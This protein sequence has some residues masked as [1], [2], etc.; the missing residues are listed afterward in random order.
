[1]QQHIK[2]R[3][4]LELFEAK[5]IIFRD[6][7]GHYTVDAL[8]GLCQKELLSDEDPIVS[9]W[10]DVKQALPKT[11]SPKEIHWVLACNSIGEVFTATLIQHEN[12]A[13]WHQF[14]S[15]YCDDSDVCFWDVCFWM[16]LP[17]SPVLNP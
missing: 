14:G 4:A 7:I 16:E 17:K 3:W 1:M 2:L 8:I 15:D 11:S 5:G 10:I 6:N 12:S 13:K 9:K